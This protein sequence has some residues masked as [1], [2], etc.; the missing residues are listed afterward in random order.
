MLK[1]G[2][3]I[4]LVL[5]VIFLW[6][7]KKKKPTKLKL[8][9]FKDSKTGLPGIRKVSVEVMDGDDFVHEGIFL[10]QGKKFSAYEVL[11]VPLGASEIECKKAFAQ[12][13][14]LDPK[15]KALYYQAYLTLT[16][17]PHT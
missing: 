5:V 16:V 15:N 12:S 3:Y 9:A 7:K 13:S 4:S 2:F 14:K 1:I 10:Y 11:A 17:T 6:K 8:E